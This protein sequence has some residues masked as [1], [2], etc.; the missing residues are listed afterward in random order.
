VYIKNAIL[1]KA[2]QLTTAIVGEKSLSIQA[3]KT[4]SAVIG[5]VKDGCSS[6]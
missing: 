1:I 3:T 2:L 5:S 4:N 6:N